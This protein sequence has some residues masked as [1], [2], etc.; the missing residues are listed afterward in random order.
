MLSKLRSTVRKLK[1]P[2]QSFS[3]TV[4]DEPRFLEDVETYFLDA[5]KRL[6]IRP[7]FYGILK[8]PVSVLKINIPLLRDN[9]RMEMI[10]AY[11]CHHKQHK[12]PLKG[13]LRLSPN[14]ELQEIEA[15]ALLMSIKLAV[16]EIPYGG[17][18]GGIKI[19]TSKYSTKEM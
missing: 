3:N 19:D 17:A 4:D 15:M 13:G 11:R 8:N 5:A 1:I 12:F 6:D 18:K 14:V 7:D 2:S 10:E 16:V 9:G